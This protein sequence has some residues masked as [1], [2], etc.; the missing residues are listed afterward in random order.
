VG[1]ELG[2]QYQSRNVETLTESCGAGPKSSH[3][4]E[5]K[6][7]VLVSIE[8]GR[9]MERNPDELVEHAM[10]AATARLPFD[11]GHEKGTRF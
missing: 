2:I 3:D 8:W 9:I 1:V 6:P 4:V 10:I 5:L 7:A 11:C